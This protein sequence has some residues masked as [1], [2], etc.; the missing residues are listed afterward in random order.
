[1]S[2]TEAYLQNGQSVII[3]R[4]NYDIEQRSHWLDIAQRFEIPIFCFV[5]P[6]ANDIT[7]CNDRAVMRDGSSFLRVIKPMSNKYREPSMNE[8]FTHVFHCSNDRSMTIFNIILT[9]IILIYKNLM[10]ISDKEN[11][12]TILKQL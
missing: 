3:D 5:L 1:M 10:L 8:G 2:T 11:A 7:F 4:C 6:H 9:I 12:L